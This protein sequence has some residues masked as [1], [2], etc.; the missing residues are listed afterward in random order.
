VALIDPLAAASHG[1]LLN[2]SAF[3]TPITVAS[4]GW[5]KIPGEIIDIPLPPPRKRGGGVSGDGGA[6]PGRRR[7]KVEPED[8][9]HVYDLVIKACFSALNDEKYEK[10][11]AISVTR[12]KSSEKVKDEVKVAVTKVSARVPEYVVEF[13]NIV[14]GFRVTAEPKTRK[15]IKVLPVSVIVSGSFERNKILK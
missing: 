12:F 14:S 1:L 7:P 6:G 5:I 4:M 10:P 9:R 15:K 8:P 11:Q 3:I 2:D 13:K